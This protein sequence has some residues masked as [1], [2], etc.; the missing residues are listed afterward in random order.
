MNTPPYTVRDYRPGDEAEINRLFNEIFGTQRSIEEWHWKYLRNPTGAVMI[1]LAEA[2]GR[3]IGHYASVP[4]WF[5]YRGAE[6]RLSMPCDNFIH[7]D[8]RGGLRG[9]QK[10]LFD[11]QLVFSDW[12]PKFGFG[13]P[14]AAHY[15]V[16]KRLLKYRDVGPM[17]VL[18]RR[19][20]PRVALAR[21]FPVLPGALVSAVA[22]VG[23]AVAVLATRAKMV[24]RSGIVT[25]NTMR[26]DARVNELWARVRDRFPV[27]CVRNQA[28]LNWRFS[29]PGV[30]YRIVTAER[31]GELAGYVVTTIRREADARIGRVVDLLADG[32]AA[33]AAL[34]GRALL[35]LHAGGADYALCWMLAERPEFTVLRAWGFDV[36]DEA[37]PP[38][39]VVSL[40]LDEE[41]ISAAVLAQPGNWYLTMADSDVF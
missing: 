21:R 16:G 37:F 6:V 10:A 24:P 23:R 27:A 31:G 11:H 18:F 19:L 38:V 30:A 7:P 39:K 20:S 32:E 4:S 40:V 34:I 13:T 5:N 25:A 26:F 1:D 29:R 36:R 9:V 41:T 17:P 2:D 22:G 8:Y 33:A 12:H 15:V 35:D 28:F 14:N 3:L